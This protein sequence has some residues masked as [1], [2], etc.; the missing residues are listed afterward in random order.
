V[1]SVFT[2]VVSLLPLL[3]SCKCCAEFACSSRESRPLT[4]GLSTEQGLAR[5][6]GLTGGQPDRRKHIPEVR[7]SHRD[8]SLIVRHGLLTF[9][10]HDFH[11]RPL[12]YTGACR[13]ECPAQTQNGGRFR[14]RISAASF[15]RLRFPHE[16]GGEPSIWQAKTIIALSRRKSTANVADSGIFRKFLDNPQPR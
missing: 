6:Y 8:F 12:P 7:S 16:R 1:S 13:A 10:N 15:V 3:Y 5:T 4:H 2:R 14:S 9:S 11:S